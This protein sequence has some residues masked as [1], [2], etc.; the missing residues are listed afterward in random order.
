MKLVEFRIFAVL[1][2][3]LF[4]SLEILLAANVLYTE[5]EV[6]QAFYS[7]LLFL[8]IPIFAAAIAKPQWGAWAAVGLAVVLLP[9]QVFQNRR[10]VQLQED[11]TLVIRHVDEQKSLTG[12]LPDNLSGYQFRHG[13]TK[14]H[15]RYHKK[16][17][18]YR[19][20]YFLNDPGI[21]Y[22]YT[23]EGGFDYYPD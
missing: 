18:E 9:W 21:G 12:K 17:R 6:M 1:L 14:D 13:W 8:N 11:V 16:D 3:L 19:I 23:S 2:V 10:L 15:V 7:F 22:W 5:G 4:A 20:D